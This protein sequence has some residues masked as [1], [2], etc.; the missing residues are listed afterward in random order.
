MNWCTGG[1]VSLW[2]CY[3]LVFTYLLTYLLTY[4]QTWVNSAFHPSGVDKWVPAIR[5]G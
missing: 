5:R 3:K 4:L 1:V 2:R